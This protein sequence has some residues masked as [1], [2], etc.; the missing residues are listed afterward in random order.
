MRKK[1]RKSTYTKAEK[2][3]VMQLYVNITEETRIIPR[4]NNIIKES[5]SKP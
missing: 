2:I 1:Q 5:I 4:N 3:K